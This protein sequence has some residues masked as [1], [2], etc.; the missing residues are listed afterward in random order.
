MAGSERVIVN[1]SPLIVLFKSQFDG[2]LG[3]LWDQVAVPDGVWS[4]VAMGADDVARRLAGAT[5]ARRVEAPAIPALVAGWDLGVGESEVLS[6]ALQGGGGR[7][8][9]DDAQ[10]RRCAKVL[11]IP[12]I[13]T[14]GLLV[15]AKRR[16]LI[17]SVGA[18]LA[19]VERSGLW[20]SRDVRDMLL[21]AAGEA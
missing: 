4:E 3:Q 12:F 17:P 15:L 14:G 2:L 7:V 13:G 21:R 20:I 8:I 18:S 1:A 16:G 19:T 10:A 5:W 6:L 11:G 9:I